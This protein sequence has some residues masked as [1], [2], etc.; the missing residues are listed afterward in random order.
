MRNLSKYILFVCL[1]WNIVGIFSIGIKDNRP[2]ARSSS[3]TKTQH[4]KK[5]QNNSNSKASSILLSECPSECNCQGLAVDC[6]S[7]SLKHVP[8]NI[9]VNAIRLYV[10]SL[11]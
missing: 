4:R 1:L 9:P 3:N 5:I 8:K 6:S 7:R 2:S 11:I 10:G